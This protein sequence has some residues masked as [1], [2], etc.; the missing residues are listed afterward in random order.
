[1]LSLNLCTDIPIAVMLW[2]RDVLKRRELERELKNLGWWFMRHG[3]NHDTWTN[4]IDLE[5]IPRHNEINEYLAR[6]ILRIAA[7]NPARE[8][9]R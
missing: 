8:V 4:G 6:K 1:M 7:S 9:K 5:Q 2:W 3:G